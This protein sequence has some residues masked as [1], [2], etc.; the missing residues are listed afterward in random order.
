MP[1]VLGYCNNEKKPVFFC[2]K[3][4]DQRLGANLKKCIDLKSFKNRYQ[5]GWDPP[6]QSEVCYQTSAL[7]PSHY[8]WIKK[9]VISMNLF[10]C[11]KDYIVHSTIYFHVIFFTYVCFDH[12]LHKC[13]INYVVWNNTSLMAL[14]LPR[15]T[16]VKFVIFNMYMKGSP[17]FSVK[18]DFL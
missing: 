7:P 18:K 6:A 3:K 8:V 10:S 15:L 14:L 5:A 1:N 16:L 17:T 12:S 4:L 13:N 9:I 2:E 11:H